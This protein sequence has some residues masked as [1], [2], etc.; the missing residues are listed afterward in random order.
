ML[1]SV[2]D[3]YQPL[4]R[5]RE[6]TR[7]CLE[8]LLEYGYGVDILTKNDLVLRDLDLFKRF[9]EVE[10]GMTITSLDDG[11]RKAFEPGASPILARLEALK[12]LD[13]AL[14][15]PGHGVRIQ[16]LSPGLRMLLAGAN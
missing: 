15:L 1:S 9:D 6:L 12:K 8:V 11:V 7:R 14:V 10:V 2:T 4:E 5:Q 3:A 13:F 16:V